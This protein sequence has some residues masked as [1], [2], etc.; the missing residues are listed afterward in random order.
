MS[1]GQRAAEHGE[2]L[3][4][5]ERRPAVNATGA[6]DD[7]VTGRPLGS[8]VEVV[9]LMDHEPVDLGERTCV[10]KDLEP[11][12]RGLLAGLVLT[13]DPFLT[14]GQLGFR[15]SATQLVEAILM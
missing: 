11:L 15:A 6:R 4:E 2:V 14:A 5:H 8:H 3:S 10:E 12:A 9:A 7:A 13:T 1:F